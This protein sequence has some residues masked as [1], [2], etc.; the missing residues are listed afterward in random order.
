MARLFTIVGNPLQDQ[1][2]GVNVLKLMKDLCPVL[3]KDL[4]ELWDNSIP[5]M[6]QHLQ[7]MHLST[8]NVLFFVH[9]IFAL[10]SVTNS[11]ICFH[12]TSF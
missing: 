4:I 10:S 3:E 6:V 5:P 1:N 2:R 12:C 9:L 8:V 7:G 11:Q